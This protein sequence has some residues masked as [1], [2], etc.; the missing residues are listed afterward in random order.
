M[1]EEMQQH[2]EINLESSV[3]RN[4]TNSINLINKMSEDLSIKIVMIG[5]VALS[6]YVNRSRFTQD[7]DFIT[8]KSNYNKIVKYL[9]KHNIDY[10]IEDSYHLIIKGH[11]ELAEIDI[12]LVFSEIQLSV[13]DNYN[14]VKL[15]NTSTKVASPEGLMIMYLI[16]DKMQNKVDAKTLISSGKF[17]YSKFTSLLRELD[18]LDKDEILA[19]YAKISKITESKYGESK[20]GRLL[21]GDRK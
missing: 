12:L 6:C 11:K 8:T 13:L 10:K 7:I 18:D 20:I 5:A 15:F 19:E 16:S 3:S 1:S 4:F 17:S 14:I 2:L 21:K 9:D